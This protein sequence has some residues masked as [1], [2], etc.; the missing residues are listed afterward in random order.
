ME[1]TGE[2]PANIILP[3]QRTQQELQQEKPGFLKTAQDKVDEN[4]DR[5]R[6]NRIQQ[7]VQNGDY[8]TA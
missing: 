1:L 2:Q 6:R 3:E 4:A 7:A 5:I 8:A